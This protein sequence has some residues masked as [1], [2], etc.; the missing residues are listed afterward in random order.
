MLVARGQTTL[1]KGSLRWAVLFG[2]NLHAFVIERRGLVFDTRFVPPSSAP[3]RESPCL[4]LLLDGELREHGA[5]TVRGPSALVVSDALL[6]G[7]NGTRSWNYQGVGE[8]CT[9]VQVHPGP[10]ETSLRSP[11]AAEPILLDADTWSAA[12][13]FADAARAD[14]ERFRRAFTDLAR[15]LHRRSIAGSALVESALRPT[16]APFQLLW[17][18]LGPMIE[19]LQLRPTVKELTS[20]TGATSREID[21][22]VRAFVSSF[23]FVGGSWRD[24]SR[25]W[26]LNLAVLF[27]SAE[28]ATVAEIAKT[29]GY[30]STD[31]MGRAF[32]DAGLPRPSDIQAE[33]SSLRPS[34]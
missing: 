21:R 9:V 25:F 3:P 17:K 22:F 4:F 23:G 18:G 30:G 7:A 27:L 5:R 26:R 34:P 28:G 33:L 24:A 32:R 6:D 16:P 10:K 12:R 2:A 15:A 1:G 8:P 14:D 13:S 20:L 31:A 11:A 19:R 29:V